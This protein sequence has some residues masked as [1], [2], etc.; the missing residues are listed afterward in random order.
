MQQ[1][2]HDRPMYVRS[3]ALKHGD[4]AGHLGM[5]AATWGAPDL[6]PPPGLPSSAG[7]PAAAAAAAVGAAGRAGPEPDEADEAAAAAGSQPPH[8]SS[9]SAARTSLVIRNMPELMTRDL[10]LGELEKHGELDAIDFVYVCVSL[11]DKRCTGQ[12]YVNFV[13]EFTAMKFKDRWHGKKEIG[14]M[15]CT[16]AN[17]KSKLNVAWA[18]HHGF[19][20]CVKQNRHKHI[21]DES[22]KA[23]VPKWREPDRRRIEG[24]AKAAAAGDSASLVAVQQAHRLIDE[25]VTA[26]AI[27]AMGW[28]AAVCSADTA[29]AGIA[30]FSPTPWAAYQGVTAAVAPCAPSGA[31]PWPAYA[32]ATDATSQW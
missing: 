32:S 7:E 12:A 13:T 9:R 16:K 10:F 11:D 2:E 8:C 6:G 3:Q 17:K 20:A 25:A 24:S 14:D 18:H 26:Y 5:P 29:F 1:P 27:A 21:K 4:D 28:P 15:S 23:W 30:A 19:E 22:M 31:W